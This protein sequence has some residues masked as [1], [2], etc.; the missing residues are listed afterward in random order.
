VV[1]GEEVD[2]ATQMLCA[3]SVAN[4]AIMQRII[5]QTSISVAVR[6]D[7]LPKIVNLRMEEKR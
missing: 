4:M 7:I 5:T 3:L 2:R 6:F 1:H